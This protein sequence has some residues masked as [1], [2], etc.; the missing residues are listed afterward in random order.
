MSRAGPVPASGSAMS[1][2]VLFR[3]DRS[4]CIGLTRPHAEQTAEQTPSCCCRSTHR[5]RRR[6][7]NR[8]AGGQATCDA[9]RYQSCCPHEDILRLWRC[10]PTGKFSSGAGRRR[11]RLKR[12]SAAVAQSADV[13]QT[14]SV[15]IP[16]SGFSSPSMPVGRSRSV[17]V[18]ARAV[19]LFRY[20]LPRI[21]VVRLSNPVTKP[22][23]TTA[24][25]TGLKPARAGFV[26]SDVA[27]AYP[28]CG[29]GCTDRGRSCPSQNWHNRDR[30][31][32]TGTRWTLA[33]CC[34][35]LQIP[36]GHDCTRCGG[37]AAVRMRRSLPRHP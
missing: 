25:S 30:T 14:C 4:Y 24:V 15:V 29:F 3:D 33:T 5:R 11:A 34:F 6:P 20:C 35:S 18:F 19:M 23:R 28:W 37:S 26:L 12:P 8:S 36:L 2:R 32:K 17:L 9:R 31:R 13:R 22:T 1:A 27:M 10:Q 16:Q 7:G 21:A